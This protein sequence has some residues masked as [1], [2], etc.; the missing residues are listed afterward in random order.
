MKKQIIKSMMLE[1]GFIWIGNM[2][3]EKDRY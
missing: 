3:H 1:R 2:D